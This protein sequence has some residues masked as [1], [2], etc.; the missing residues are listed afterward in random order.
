MADSPEKE[1]LTREAEHLVAAAR[2]SLSDEMVTRMAGTATDAMDLIDRINTSGLYRAI[3]AIAEMVNSGDL[4]RVARLARLYNSA[5]DALTDDMVTRLAGTA[6]DAMD[7]LDRVNTSG[8]YRAIPAIAEMVNSGDLDRIARLARL[9]NSAE[10]ALTDDMV[11][12]IAETATEGLSLLDRLSRG[13]AGRM[14]EMLARMEASGSLKRIADTLPKLLERLEMLDAVL[15]AV[16][17]ASAESAQEPKSAGGLG[18]LWSLMREPDSQDTLRY[19]MDVGK[20]VRSATT[21]R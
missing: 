14:V 16:E 15:H 12:R 21:P 6:T 17:K 10:D 13:G 4:D 8:L 2:D 11:N 20:A 3:P 7:L 18:G 19:L 5:E 9:Y 1:M